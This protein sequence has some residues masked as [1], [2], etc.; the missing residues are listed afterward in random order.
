MLVYRILGTVLLL[1]LLIWIGFV[2]TLTPGYQPAPGFLGL[3]SAFEGSLQLPA[4]RIAA[5]FETA[6]A[7]M[8]EVNAYGTRLRFA[9][10]L[11]GWFSFAAT[12]AITL[13]VGF[14]GRSPQT[15]GAGAN[16]DG[17]PARS[18]RFIGF[19][20]ALAAI[21]TA[22]NSMAVAKAGDYYKQ[23]DG[24]RDLLVQSRVEVIDAK[25]AEAAQ[26]VLDRLAVHI[27]R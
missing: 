6:R 2:A 13:I 21:L 7:R 9:G 12:A 5:A 25:S 27:T 23:A 17:L 19:L 15:A 8:L 24:I 10:D 1:A 20:A 14:Y 22:F 3:G 16:T 26:A 11:A 18:V 4:E